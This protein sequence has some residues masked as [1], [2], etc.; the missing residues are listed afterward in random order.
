MTLVLS[1]TKLFSTYDVLEWTQDDIAHRS[2]EDY[3]LYGEYNHHTAKKFANI[4]G[5]HGCCVLK[6]LVSEESRVAAWKSVKK[7]VKILLSHYDPVQDEFTDFDQEENNIVRMPRIGRGK[8]NI[9]F[10][11]E[12]SEQH[13][14]LAQL[15][16]DSHFSEMLSIYMGKK[17]TLRETGL[18]VTRPIYNDEN[19]I[20]TE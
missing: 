13:K 11:P 6:D 20:F 10:D 14:V 12:F 17:C 7:F 9:H 16:Y 1:P 2:I 5:R 15:T 4:I 8:H 19:S 3:A 18:T